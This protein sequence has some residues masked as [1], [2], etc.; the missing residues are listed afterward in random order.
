[1]NRQ[2]KNKYEIIK[3]RRAQ[4]HMWNQG[5]S[6]F[7]CSEALWFPGIQTQLHIAINMELQN[8]EQVGPI[9]IEPDNH[10]YTL[11]VYDIIKLDPY[12]W[13]HV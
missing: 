2:E 1:M 13:N 9:F 4:Q 6:E 10:V 7:H 3:H 5:S 12:S 8:H 11:P